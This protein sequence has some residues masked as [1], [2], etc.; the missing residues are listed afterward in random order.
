MA[1]CFTLL[2]KC[3]SRCCGERESVRPVRMASHL[4]LFDPE[5]T[6]EFTTTHTEEDSKIE[7]ETSVR[8]HSLLTTHDLLLDESDPF[9][10]T[11]LTLLPKHF[12][13][14]E[15]FSKVEFKRFYDYVTFSKLSSAGITRILDS[16]AD[17]EYLFHHFSEVTTAF[18]TLLTKTDRQ[19]EVLPKIRELTEQQFLK[20]IGVIAKRTTDQFPYHNIYHA[21]HIRFYFAM[22]YNRWS[23]QFYGSHASSLGVIFKLLLSLMVA[24]HDIEVRKVPFVN[25]AESAI[26]AAEAIEDIIDQL[27]DEFGFTG[28][29]ERACLT[30]FKELLA[31]IARIVIIDGT[32]LVGD[33]QNVIQS[34]ATVMANT[35]QI[36]SGNSNFHC[37]EYH[38][39]FS[40]VLM[41]QVITGLC[42]FNT[43]S[44]LA[45]PKSKSMLV[46]SRA[47]LKH[48][49]SLS[50]LAHHHD[51][52]VE[53]LFKKYSEELSGLSEFME[54][55]LLPQDSRA[56]FLRCLQQS[57]LLSYEFDARRQQLKSHQR[58]LFVRLLAF[59]RS[60]DGSSQDNFEHFCLDVD[61]SDLLAIADMYLNSLNG[62]QNFARCQDLKLFHQIADQYG[63]HD[64]FVPL[65]DIDSWA[66]H[67]KNLEIF[68]TH[69]KQLE[70]ADKIKLLFSLFVLSSKQE[71][72]DLFCREQ[73]KF[74]PALKGVPKKQV[75]VLS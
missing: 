71:G 20:A 65:I 62:E 1:Y 28:L 34:M 8:I 47:H 7:S 50:D 49:E 16:L 57:F 35:E 60:I 59:S 69:V 56:P 26:Y 11:L 30:K 24:V 15:K 27:G 4:S 3:L 37:R 2:Y 32:T 74:E 64:F 5:L 23:K 72:Y 38:E 63:S 44:I 17:R 39:V 29:E 53:S 18:S 42:D 73:V 48:Y 9:Y 67:E 14:L 66:Q 54:K 40:P 22:I 75:L 68:K 46:Q 21:I 70:P 45:V 36:L 19:P 31:T 10:K 13:L 52:D 43:L 41:G 6:T 25:E 51:Y 55:D 61:Q 33:F 12:A 58:E